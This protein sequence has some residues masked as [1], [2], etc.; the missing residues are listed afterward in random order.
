LNDIVEHS[1]FVADQR[2]TLISALQLIEPNFTPVFTPIDINY[3]NVL[4]NDLN[5]HVVPIDQVTDPNDTHL[6]GSEVMETKKGFVRDELEAMGRQQLEIE[7]AGCVTVPSI[8]KFPPPTKAV[9]HYV[10]S[11]GALKII[12]KIYLSYSLIYLQRA[13]LQEIQDSWRTQIINAFNRDIYTLRC[14]TKAVRAINLL[15]YLRALE[16]EQYAEILL[17]EIKALSSGSDTY[18]PTVGSL[19]RELGHKVQVK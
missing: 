14:Q 9:L 1:K 5:K 6:P 8:E 18:T 2:E 3:S 16:V 13:K 12:S 4:L 17:R 11:E 15:P 10:S 19:Y 7:L